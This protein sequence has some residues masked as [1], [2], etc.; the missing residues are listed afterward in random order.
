MKNTDFLKH[1]TKRLVSRNL[2]PLLLFR[3]LWV[4]VYYINKALQQENIDRSA[5]IYTSILDRHLAAFPGNVQK[6]CEPIVNATIDT[7]IGGGCCCCCLE[8][9]GS[10]R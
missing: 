5:G 2:G 7:L 1:Q 9:T 4:Y 10:S 6:L 3:R 8:A